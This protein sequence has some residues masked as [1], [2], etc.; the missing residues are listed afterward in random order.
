MLPSFQHSSSHMLIRSRAYSREWTLACLI[1]NVL[2]VKHCDLYYLYNNIINIAVYMMMYAIA[3]CSILLSS[4]SF[5]HK[6]IAC[7]LPLHRSLILS[8][9]CATRLCSS[10]N[11]EQSRSEHDEQEESDDDRTEVGGLLLLSNFDLRKRKEEGIQR[12][13]RQ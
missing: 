7:I 9:E 2:F 6:Y 10:D 1:V 3:C 4:L 12:W 5:D 8:L 13:D 11:G